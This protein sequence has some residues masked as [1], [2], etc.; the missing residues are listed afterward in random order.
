[1]D[2]RFYTPGWMRK[3]AEERWARDGEA[4]IRR[5][6]EKMQ[7]EASFA[8]QWMDGSTS[9]QRD[10]LLEREDYYRKRLAERPKPAP[11][12]EPPPIEKPKYRKPDRSAW[13]RKA[14]RRNVR[15]LHPDDI[16]SCADDIQDWRG[17][18]TPSDPDEIF[19]LGLMAALRK[20]IVFGRWDQQ[21]YTVDDRIIEKAESWHNH[22]RV[23]A[24]DMEWNGY[25]WS[26]I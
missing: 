5:V 11:I 3:A 26:V 8:G 24:R 9:D 6:E 12:P 23:D 4:E 2:D 10:M 1:M 22:W 21:T 17:D 25:E 7:A 19:Y 15:Q 14:T 16:D 18:C 20:S 13:K